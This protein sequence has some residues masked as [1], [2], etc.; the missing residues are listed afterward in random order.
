MP[1][2]RLESRRRLTTTAGTTIK[3]VLAAL[4]LLLPGLTWSAEASDLSDETRACL[5]CHDKPTLSQKM[6]DGKTLSLH[7][8]TDLF[9][10]SQHSETDCEDCHSDIDGDTHGKGKVKTVIKNRREHSMGMRESC[11]DC[12]KKNF[13]AYED[14]VHAAMVAEG[15]E[16]APLCS[17]C[18]NSHTLLSVKEEV[19]MDQVP[20][21]NCHKE[22]FKAYAGDVH[23]LKRAAKVKDAPLCAN[24]HKAHDGK[25]ASLGNGIK[26]SCLACHED[27]EAKHKGWLPNAARHFEAI[28]CPACH[29]PDAKRRVNLRLFDSASHTQLREKTGVPQFKDWTETADT[30]KMGLDERALRSM[31]KEFSEEGGKG[32]TILMG[33]LEVQSGVEAH[34]LSDKSKAIKACSSCHSQGAEPFQSVTVTMAGPDGRP[35]RHGVQKEVLNSLI[36][37]DSVRGFYAIGANR[38]KL[39]DWLLLLAVAGSIAGAAMH[40]TVRWGF[41]RAREKAEAESKASAASDQASKS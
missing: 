25:A 20:C 1:I 28:S 21:A 29:N 7:V 34:Q 27:A 18:H 4:L 26:D 2:Q 37:L 19:P 38:I 22:I 32:K 12:H 5:K 23:G 30:Q 41:R 33:R 16:K 17:N 31:L 8:S 9:L 3:G 10:K 36:S 11:R 15:S 24:C 35:V 39:L 13:K 6:E 40:A 14:G